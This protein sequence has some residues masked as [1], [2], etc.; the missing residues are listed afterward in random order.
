VQYILIPMKSNGIA[1]WLPIEIVSCVWP[2]C[3]RSFNEMKKY[4][5]KY[6]ILLSQYVYV[7]IRES[8][9]YAIC[10]SVLTFFLLNG[11]NGN[12]Q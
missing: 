6:I 1:W 11:V 3:K 7:A 9:C 8:W 5:E 4:V 2:R 10:N 12:Y